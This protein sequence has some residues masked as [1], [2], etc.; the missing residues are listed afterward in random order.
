MYLNIRYGAKGREM[1]TVYSGKWH[2]KQVA[3]LVSIEQKTK[4]T[5]Y[6]V[7]STLD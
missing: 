5:V 1:S 4:L 3:Q 6:K 7:T 2:S